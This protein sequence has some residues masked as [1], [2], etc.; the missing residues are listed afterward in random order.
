MLEKIEAKKDRRDFHGII[1]Y[2]C[3]A[4]GR[5]ENREHFGKNKRSPLEFAYIIKDD[6]QQFRM[7]H[8]RHSIEQEA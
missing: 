2:F 7:A 4:F 1:V 3:G 6:I 5:K 8:S